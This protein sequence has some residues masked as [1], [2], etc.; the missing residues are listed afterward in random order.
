MDQLT[1]FKERKIFRTLISGPSGQG[2]TTLAV[3]ILS[4]TYFD[5]IFLI[6]ATA[7]NQDI[8]KLLKT[9]KIYYFGIINDNV[10]RIII[11]VLKKQNYT[12][13]TLLFID[14]MSDE[15]ILNDRGKGVLSKITFNARWFNLNVMILA[16]SITAVSK[17]LRDNSNIIYIY[18]ST[19][20]KEAETVRDEWCGNID[21]KDFN[22]WYNDV[23]DTPHAF[24]II[25]KN[26]FKV[27]KGK[28]DDLSLQRLQARLKRLKHEHES[29]P[30]IA[31]YKSRIRS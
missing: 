1:T 20:R 9:K 26:P 18:P 19:R 3:H 31:V 14:D 17:A 21:K 25:N 23:L 24:I 12:L 6:S 28:I 11:N 10:F 29:D 30:N 15:S 7:A 27:S 2:K 22:F 4:K 8:Y 16:H 13:N 5:Q